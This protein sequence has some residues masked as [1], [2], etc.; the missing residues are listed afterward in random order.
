[1]DTKLQ[2]PKYIEIQTQSLCN[3]NCAICPY[4]NISKTR[5]TNGIARMPEEL[6]KR[7][8]DELELH[9][10]EVERIIPYMNNEPFL[11]NRMMDILRYIKEKGFFVELSTNASALSENRSEQIIKDRLIDDFRISFFSGYEYLYRK[12]MPGLNYQKTLHNIQYFLQM[13]KENGNPVPVQIIQVMHEKMDLK[14]EQRKMKELFPEVNIHYFGYLDRAGNMK[15]KND[16]AIK[17]F[18]GASLRGCSLAR[19]E[20]RFTITAHGEVIICSQDWLN[21]EVIGNIAKNRIE[22]IFLG[23]QRERLLRQL[24][25]ERDSDDLFLCKRC[26]LANVQTDGSEVISQN[27][28]GD[29]FMSPSDEKILL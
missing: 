26:K 4:E 3:A 20:E 5:G 7:I 17:D 28:S 18:S 6:I 16:L 21:K 24:Y 19:L 27:F 10:E 22:D 2:F 23:K 8:I 25:G 1:M 15:C 12:I 13:N 9:K 11:D 29:K 14:A